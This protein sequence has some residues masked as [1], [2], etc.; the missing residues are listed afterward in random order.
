MEQ[1]LE[2]TL[3]LSASTLTPASSDA[4]FRSYYRL[5]LNNG[6]RIVMDAPPEQENSRPFV[7]IA[8][9]L[10]ATGLNVP[11]VLIA[12][13]EQGFL[14]LSDLGS[15]QYLSA[16]NEHSADRLYGDAMGALITLQACGP[17][18][19]E[20]PPY[21]AALLQQEMQLFIDW[22][23][24]RH[25]GLS[26]DAG[27]QSLFD[28]L[29]ARLTDSALA[30][31][32]VAVHRDYHSRNLMVAAH[33]P[34]ILD[35]QDAVHGPVTYDLVSLLRDCY[36]DWPRERVEGWALGYQELAIDSGIL[37]QRNEE[38]FLRWFDWMGMQR[39]LK[40][41]GIFARL[42]QRDGK[43]AY[44]AD[45]PRTLNYLR[46]VSGRYSELGNFHTWMQE[47]LPAAD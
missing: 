11:D 40:A 14:L 34:G 39:H 3:G 6:S 17:G 22:Y 21:D 4:S 23:L 5:Q 38:T 36:I 20:L 7:R 33:N 29:F 19:G 9:M 43:P 31:P 28:D 46:E 44:L 16:L 45:I 32:Q 1:W 30:Q 27:E 13:L 35:F 47:K 25:L 41:V 12:D 2:Q 10:Q 18:E 37:R 24:Q 42:A 15:E 8:Q 26:L